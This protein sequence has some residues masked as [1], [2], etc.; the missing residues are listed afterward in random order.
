MNNMSQL[1]HFF[2]LLEYGI[3]TEMSRQVIGRKMWPTLLEEDVLQNVQR[4]CANLW[5]NQKGRKLVPQCNEALMSRRSAE[6]LAK[7][8][9]TFIF[10]VKKTLKSSKLKKTIERNYKDQEYYFET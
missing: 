5:S 10:L 2:R 1:F 8:V 7:N 6:K 3:R 4:G 9:E